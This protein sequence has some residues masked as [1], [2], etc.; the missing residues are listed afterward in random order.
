[1]KIKDGHNRE[2]K[3]I[4]I[5]LFF[6]FCFLFT[7]YNMKAQQ[8]PQY[9]QYM[10]NSFTLNP[11][12]AGT[13]PYFEACSDNRYQWV[14]ITDAPRTYMLT[15]DGPITQ[16]HIGI[17]GYVYT[18]VTGPVSHT[19]FN[20]AYSYHLEITKGLN[21]SMGL[22]VGIMQFAVNGSQIS[23]EE[24]GDPALTSAQESVIVP[25][26]GCG[27]YLYGRNFYFGFAAPQIVQSRLQITQMSTPANE[28]VTHYY[29][30]A[31]YNFDLGHDFSLDPCVLAEYVFP[32]PIQFD[33][34]LRV[35]YE[36]KFWLGAGYRTLDAVYAMI[37]YVYQDNLTFGYS[38]DYSI[39]DIRN[40][41]FGT[42]EIFIG[43]KFDRQKNYKGVPQF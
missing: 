22:T 42:N 6:F 38:Y 20:S 19:G 36:K 25:D 41:S 30:T 23:L 7:A 4:A 11:A 39:T 8:L 34:N 37:G 29:T 40:Y 10:I 27:A 28:L 3:N 2:R 26:I 13:Q 9:T 17:G 32:A 5:A 14:G 18:D 15:F 33:F 24:V 21:L 16:Q 31:G 35:L 43:I 1:M 12:V